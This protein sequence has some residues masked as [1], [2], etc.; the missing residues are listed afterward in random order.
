MQ[1]SARHLVALLSITLAACAAPTAS[2]PPPMTFFVTSAGPGRGGDLGGLEG[3]DAHC[4]AL[5]AQSGQPGAGQLSWR[6]Y[7]SQQSSLKDRAATPAI[8]ARDRIGPGPWHNAQGVLIARDV[9]ELHNGPTNGISR[10]TAL[11]ER[12]EQ[13]PGRVH[14]ILTGTRPDGLAPSPLDADMS[15]RNWRSSADLAEDGSANGALV[16]HHDRASAIDEPWAKS[17]NSAH[18]SRG[19]SPAKLAELG[20]GGRFYCF[21][22]QP[23][24]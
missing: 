18:R 21:A 7:L 5:A 3:A 2:P 22:A 9:D 23:K 20:S 14:D 11:T 8:N 12:G 13:V 4:Q 24:P 10:H 16:G 1:T 6:A 17:W 19:C 15:C